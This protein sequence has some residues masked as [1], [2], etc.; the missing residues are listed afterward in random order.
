MKDG[1]AIL[2]KALPLAPYFVGL[3]YFHC[4]RANKVGFARMRLVGENNGGVSDHLWACAVRRRGKRACA[5]GG[6]KAKELA[7]QE[8]KLAVLQQ[9]VAVE[10]VAREK[11]VALVMMESDK[12]MVDFIKDLTEARNS[13][14]A[15]KTIREREL[16][17]EKALRERTLRSWNRSWRWKG[18][19]GRRT[20]QLP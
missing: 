10:R 5:P 14:S 17:A 15:Q 9:R 11:D 18:R 2:L 6:E 4:P 1:L 12:R 7:I 3:V 8:A 20:S 13:A 16:A 19:L